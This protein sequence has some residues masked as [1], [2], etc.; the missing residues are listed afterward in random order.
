MLPGFRERLLIELKKEAK[1]DEELSGLVSEF[2]FMDV[3]IPV[4]YL[5]WLGASIVGSLEK[6]SLDHSIT[7]NDW[8]NGNLTPQQQQQ[9]QNSPIPTPDRSAQSSPVESIQKV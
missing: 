4:N 6:F 5:G 3:S 8:A 2:G 1:A 7:A 9:Q